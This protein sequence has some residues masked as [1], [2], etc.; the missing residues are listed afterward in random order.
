MAD[1]LDMISTMHEV[2]D[3]EANYENGHN[4]CEYLQ[5]ARNWLRNFTQN[6]L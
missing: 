2:F 1:E 4:I 6:H 3:I 5:C